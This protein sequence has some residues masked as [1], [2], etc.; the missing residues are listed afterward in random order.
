MSDSLLRFVPVDPEFQPAPSTAAL[1][2]EFLRK[3]LPNAERIAAKALHEVEFIDAGAN[4][5][6]VHC[7]L[8]GA[9]AEPWWGDSMSQAAE[10][11][12]RSLR[13]L[14]GCCQRSV[15]LNELRYGWPVGFAR[16][17][18][19]AHSPQSEGLTAP[20]L[21]QLSGIVGCAVR[22]IPVHL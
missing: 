17:V 10:S 7:P 4:W 14:S 15:S 20:Q 6:G 3:L 8:C 11:G 1:A 22:E 16:F 13:V 18:L 9:D 21:E 2:E 19:E 12:F 5:E